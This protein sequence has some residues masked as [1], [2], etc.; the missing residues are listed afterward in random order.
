MHEKVRLVLTS[1]W[2]LVA[3]ALA[4]LKMVIPFVT[5]SLADGLW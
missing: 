5:R 2:L 4:S 3:A 1:F